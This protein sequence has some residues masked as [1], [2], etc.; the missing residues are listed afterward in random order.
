MFCLIRLQTLVQSENGIGHSIK[1]TAQ[2]SSTWECLPRFPIH[3]RARYECHWNAARRAAGI[4]VQK[5]QNSWNVRYAVDI[6]HDAIQPKQRK[7]KPL[8]RGAAEYGAWRYACA[9]LQQTCINT[10]TAQMRMLQLFL[11]SVILSKCHFRAT[12]SPD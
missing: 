3:I 1:G 2:N 5:L 11:T 10:T 7:L 12:P 4:A 9:V 8:L 6:P